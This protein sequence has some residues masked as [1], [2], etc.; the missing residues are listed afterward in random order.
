MRE[1]DVP[2]MSG[3]SL[4][5]VNILHAEVTA[6]C[7]AIGEFLLNEPL[8]VDPLVEKLDELR[9]TCR[10]LALPAAV[11]LVDELHKTVNALVKRAASPLAVQPELSVI[12]DAF[13]RLF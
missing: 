1:G 9:G 5:I 2:A 4:D 12:V 6:L 13:P 11:S 10:L 7:G 3:I 8:E